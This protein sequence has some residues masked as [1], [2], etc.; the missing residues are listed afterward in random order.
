[1]KSVQQLENFADGIIIETSIQYLD[2][3]EISTGSNAQSQETHIQGMVI[4]E[5]IV[6]GLQ[7]AVRCSQAF[8]WIQPGHRD[9]AEASDFEMAPDIKW[10]FFQQDGQDDSEGGAW[11]EAELIEVLCSTTDIAILNPLV[12]V[13]S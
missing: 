9:Y 5:G 2:A 11:D 4:N 7:L 13:N 8:T 1:M 12:T 10:E 3:Q 6:P